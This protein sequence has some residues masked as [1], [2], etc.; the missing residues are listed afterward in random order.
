[1]HATVIA[2]PTATGVASALPAPAGHRA[3]NIP[4]S[5]LPRKC[6]CKDSAISNRNFQLEFHFKL[7]LDANR[8]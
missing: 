1:M 8:C 4:A 5:A 6:F 7:E 2:L 3:R